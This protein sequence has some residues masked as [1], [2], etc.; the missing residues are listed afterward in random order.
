MSGARLRRSPSPTKKHHMGCAPLL[1]LPGSRTPAG[2]MAGASKGRRVPQPSSLFFSFVRRETPSRRVEPSRRGCDAL[3]W[4]YSKYWSHCSGSS[5]KVSQNQLGLG[6]PPK[7]PGTV[8]SARFARADARLSV[9]FGWG[10]KRRTLEGWSGAGGFE[11][12]FRDFTRADA[13]GSRVSGLVAFVGTP[14]PSPVPPRDTACLGGLVWGCPGSLQA[15]RA[16][17]RSPRFQTAQKRLN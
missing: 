17:P 3:P 10:L 11:P 7:L 13:L 8:I 1:S 9:P 5:C 6:N 4:S 2:R 14:P 12:G 16:L 15:R